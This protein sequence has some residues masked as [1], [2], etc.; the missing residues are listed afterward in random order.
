MK[1]I[2]YVVFRGHCLLR[3]YMFELQAMTSSLSLARA[4]LVVNVI[5][6]EI[7]GTCWSSC[8]P[9]CCLRN[10]RCCCVELSWWSGGCIPHLNLVPVC[11]DF[12]AD[13]NLLCF[14]RSIALPRQDCECWEKGW[15]VRE[16]CS[17]HGLS[18]AGRCQCR[19]RCVV[20]HRD[21]FKLN[22]PSTGC[23]A[24]A[25]P[26]KCFT[27]QCIKIF[28]NSCLHCVLFACVSCVDHR[29]ELA[30][31]SASNHQHQDWRWNQHFWHA[32]A[33][34]PGFWLKPL[35]AGAAVVLKT[36]FGVGHGWSG[37]GESV[38]PMRLPSPVSAVDMMIYLNLG[39]DVAHSIQ[40]KLT[41]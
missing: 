34:F 22:I 24:C 10:N 38:P 4:V 18:I 9:A 5:H 36:E 33:V 8:A 19:M 25:L 7:E 31:C 40:Q 29:V 32:E 28:W 13:L 1:I 30:L 11:C 37:N 21:V 35:D 27:L 3:K 17:T 39:C 14:F 15:F 16:H 2:C 26:T 23:S 20:S 6:A 41:P 12:T